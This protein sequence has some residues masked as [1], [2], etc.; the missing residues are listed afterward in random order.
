MSFVPYSSADC[1]TC[2][3]DILDDKCSSRA[4][5]A[6]CDTAS[7]CRQQGLTAMAFTSSCAGES[8]SSV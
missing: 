8:L 1:G 4:T 6:G 5:R 7:L 3:V 2:N